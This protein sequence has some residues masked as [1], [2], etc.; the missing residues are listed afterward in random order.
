MR[1]SLIA[2][3]HGDQLIKKVQ[4]PTKLQKHAS[5]LT[6]G[7]RARCPTTGCWQRVLFLSR[8]PLYLRRSRSVTNRQPKTKKEYRWS[9]YRIR[10]TPAAFVGSVYALMKRLP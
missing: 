6:N 4:N 3:R 7:V 10:W 8:L 5:E 9:A 1:P 2:Q